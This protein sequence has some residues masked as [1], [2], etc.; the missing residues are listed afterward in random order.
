[1]AEKF[2]KIIDRKSSEIYVNKKKEI[3]VDGH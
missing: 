2:N 1:M 3:T